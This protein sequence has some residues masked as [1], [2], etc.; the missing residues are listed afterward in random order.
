L[1]GK[2]YSKVEIFEITESD[3]SIK[4]VNDDFL[5]CYVN[6][7]SPITIIS[8]GPYGI[9]G[10]P[11]DLKSPDELPNWYRPFINIWT[12]ASSPQTT[13]WFWNTEV[14]WANVH[15]LLLEAGWDYVSCHIWDMGL[16][17]VAGKVNSKTIRQFPIV[18]EVCVQYVRRA[19]FVF[20]DTK[21]P[22]K[23]WLRKEWE[24]TGLPFSKTNE[25]CG[26]RNA[27]TR[28]YFTKCHLWYFPPAE[29]FDKFSAYA[30]E[31]G[32]P[33]G[34]PYFSIDGTFPISKEEWS[35]MRSKFNANHGI[36]NVWRTPPLSGVERIKNGT[37]AL[38]TNQKPLKLMSTIIE[39]SSD[40]GDVIWEPFGGLCT[41]AIASW[42]LKRHCYSSELNK[43]VYYHAK[44]RLM[45]TTSQLQLDHLSVA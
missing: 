8:D 38:H 1:F 25:A 9:N 13:L 36:T 43:Q 30:N 20:N 16:A 44:Q 45:N 41:A 33:T 6:W 24:R 26:V 4:L 39:A 31:Y 21:I 5:N 32:N 35:K 18:T 28:K 37:K 19:E 2:K 3:K 23:E 10:Y 14:G 27:A 17:H 7:K 22:M 12:K 40:K 34:K 29:A 15:P 11:G 42:N